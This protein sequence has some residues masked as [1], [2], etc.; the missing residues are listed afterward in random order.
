MS[1]ESRIGGGVEG[2]TVGLGAG[3]L[4]GAI[5]YSIFGKNTEVSKPVL[6]SLVG[7]QAGILAGTLTGILLEDKDIYY[8]KAELDSGSANLSLQQMKQIQ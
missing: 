6:G 5:I 3:A 2:L 4:T 1:V 8:L 7:M